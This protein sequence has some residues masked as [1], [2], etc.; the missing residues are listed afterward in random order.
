MTKFIIVA[1]QVVC[2]IAA[3][4]RHEDFVDFGN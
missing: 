2:F 1:V 3:A 4:V